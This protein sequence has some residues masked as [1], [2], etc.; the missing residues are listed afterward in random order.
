MMA[1]LRPGK[2]LPTPGVLLVGVLAA[3]CGIVA[4]GKAFVGPA[5]SAAPPT[6]GVALRGASSID[7]EPKD[8][9]NAGSL[10]FGAS[11]MVLL[12]K[13]ASSMRRKQS[14]SIVRTVLQ[15]EDDDRT[16]LEDLE[17]GEKEF[18]GKVVRDARIGVYI[19]IG[20][21]KEALL[22]RTMVP[23]GKSYEAG[24]EI[25]GLKIFQVQVGETPQERKI[26]VTLG[27]LPSSYDVGDKVRGTV[28][29]VAAFGVFFDIGAL[30]DALAPSARL[31]KNPNDYA[32][33]EEVDLEIISVEEDKISVAVP[34]MAAP[35]S[36]PS[37][38]SLKV[39]QTVTGTVARVNEQYGVFFNIGAGR[40]ALCFT[41]QLDKELGDYKEGDKVEG[42]RIAKI[43]GDKVEVT[44]R[45]LAS[46][47]KVGEKV[48]GIVM[49]KIKAGIFFDA[50]FSSDVL[51][52]LSMLS[53]P[54][55]EY[56]EQEVADLTIMQVIDDK[57]TVSDKDAKPLSTFIR[58]QT[59]VGKVVKVEAQRMFLDV[60]ASQDAIWWTN[61]QVLPKEYQEGEEVP[62]LMVTKAD[63][64]SQALEVALEGA[65]FIQTSVSTSTLKVGQEV[66]GKVSRAMPFG[67]FVDVGAERDALYAKNQL[68]KPLEE[69]KPGMELTGLRVT[70]VDPE[71]QQLA[72]SMRPGASDYTVGDEV[73]GKVTKKMPFGLFVDIGACVDAL[74]PAALLEKPLDE[75][76]EDEE[77]EGL[78][79]SRLNPD[80][81]QISV[82]Q[83]GG[84]DD[85]SAKISFSDL[86][87]GKQIPG[88]VRAVREYGAFIDIGLGR[89][90]ALMPNSMMGD[91]T[92]A[93]FKPNQELEVWVVRVDEENL[94][95]TVSAVEP[96]A[97]MRAQRRGSRGPAKSEPNSY[98][99]EGFMI[100]DPKRHC[101]MLG[102]RE[103]LMDVEPTPW[104]E[105]A[106]KYPG[107]VKF[108]EEDHVVVISANAY[109]FSA[110]R[111]MDHSNQVVL[112][113]PKHLQKPDAVQPDD[114]PV[115]VKIEEADMPNYDYGI[116]PEIH[117]KYRQPPMND[118]NWRFTSLPEQKTTNKSWKDVVVEAGPF[119]P[120][121]KPGAKKVKEESG[122]EK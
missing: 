29:N 81:N 107:F 119:V 49:T 1:Q 10:I 32:V 34:G 75:Y 97:E 104:Y 117:T 24:D 118:P 64:A 6:V 36:K 25:S 5:T 51:A 19:D 67:V 3:V 112:N 13:A 91:T 2:S 100:P 72:V 70:Q 21:E 47:A 103:E 38:G 85:S 37:S 105:W 48:Q 99:P 69:Y 73:S 95:V 83:K 114:G 65:E 61:R 94:R 57:I 113:I 33:G 62:G 78:Q 102:G 9:K 52:P 44:T 108:Q 120:E 14:R 86:Q 26:R 88:V 121:E 53:K 80:S 7:L 116:S 40:D 96:T 93:A 56:S 50:G 20:A 79:I 68:E 58:G 39:G 46:E 74:L 115:R 77:L 92:S 42:L 22:P 17:V 109:G 87:E 122:D 28:R 84:Q 59:V 110:V 60:G 71:K 23:K 82:S 43:D 55:E 11:A 101:E 111:E 41:N 98:I 90:D 27:A 106:E 18:T 12:V 15:A 30:R 54:I 76:A 16:K 89:T 4:C 31:A 8:Q 35:S 66:S 45:P 63:A